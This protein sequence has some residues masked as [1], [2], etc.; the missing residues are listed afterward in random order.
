MSAHLPTVPWGIELLAL[1]RKIALIYKG[2]AD[3]SQNLGALARVFAPEIWA[4]AGFTI[5]VLVAAISVNNKVF[6]VEPEEKAKPYH[7]HIVSSPSCSLPDA[8]ITY[9]LFQSEAFWQIIQMIS[10]QFSGHPEHFSQV[11]PVTTPL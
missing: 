3:L 2:R 5:L 9:A 1:G 10:D 6:A 4:I 11:S 7:K 8:Q